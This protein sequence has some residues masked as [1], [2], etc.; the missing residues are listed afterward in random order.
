MHQH[1]LDAMSIV[2]ALGEPDLFITVFC[3]PSWEE[4]STSAKR[5]WY[6]TQ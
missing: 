6:P 1:Y 2:E 3:N 4:I 5:N